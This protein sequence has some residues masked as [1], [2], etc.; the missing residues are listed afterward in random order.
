M[1][2]NIHLSAWNGGTYTRSNNTDYPK[3]QTKLEIEFEEYL[4]YVKVV[5]SRLFCKFCLGTHVLFEEYLEYIKVAPSRLF[6]KLCFGT[7]GLFEEL[8]R[9]AKGVSHKSVLIVVL[10]RSRSSM[11]FLNEHHM[12]S[13]DLLFGLFKGSPS[14]GYF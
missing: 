8:G 3:Q 7:H 14:Y 9:H 12:I 6:H 13:R 1:K 4:E 10:V 5:P 11:F 2:V